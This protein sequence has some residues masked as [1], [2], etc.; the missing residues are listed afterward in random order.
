MTIAHIGDRN[1]KIEPFTV[2]EDVSTTMVPV[3]F[4]PVLSFACGVGRWGIIRVIENES[5]S[6]EPDEGENR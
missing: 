2:R 4:A 6:V 5:C 1:C 3:L